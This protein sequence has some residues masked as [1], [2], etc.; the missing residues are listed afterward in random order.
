[1]IVFLYSSAPGNQ[2]AVVAVAAAAMAAAAAAAS[3]SPS[4]CESMA[5]SLEKIQGDLAEIKKALKVQRRQRCAIY[6]TRQ[7][8][9]VQNCLMHD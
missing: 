1:M 5:S 3:Q 8:S 9:V 4:A 7:L 6:V 2:K